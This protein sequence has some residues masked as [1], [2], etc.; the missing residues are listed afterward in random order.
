MFLTKPKWRAEHDAALALLRHQGKTFKQIA[1]SINRQFR[2]NFTDNGAKNRFNRLNLKKTYNGKWTIEADNFIL[3]CTNNGMTRQQT[4]NMFNQAFNSNVTKNA[5][6]G[7]ILRLRD[8]GYE[9]HVNIWPKIVIKN[10]KRLLDTCQRI[11]DIARVKRHA[12]SSDNVCVR[13]GCRGPRQR[14]VGDG[15]LCAECHYILKVA[16]LPRLR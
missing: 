10:P 6:I 7:R 3:R 4:A 9:T 16:S 5:V 2:T 15:K 12:P 13:D 8:M 14:S 11:A 1:E